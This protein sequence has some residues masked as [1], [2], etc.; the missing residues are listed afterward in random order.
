MSEPLQSI[1]LIVAVALFVLGGLAFLT[2]RSALVALLGVELMANAAGLAF[3]VFSRLSGDLGGHVFYLF[4]M[5]VAAAE[6]AVGLALIVAYSRLRKTTALD[7]ATT[8]Q[9]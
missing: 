7:E 3:L 5:A 2:R 6:A 9:G 4:I 8:L 1:G